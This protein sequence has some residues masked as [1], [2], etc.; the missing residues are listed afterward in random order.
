MAGVITVIIVG[1]AAVFIIS[2]SRRQHSPIGA[3][4]SSSDNAPLAAPDDSDDRDGQD[5]GGP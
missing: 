5:E 4:R 3:F 1:I 2:R